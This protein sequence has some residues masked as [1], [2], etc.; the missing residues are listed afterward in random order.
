MPAMLRQVVGDF[1]YPVAIV[2]V[3]VLFAAPL[4][5]FAINWQLM[6]YWI[7]LPAMVL[8]IW[9]QRSRIAFPLFLVLLAHLV[10]SEILPT[11]APG[12]G[13]SGQVV[14]AALVILLPV[15]LVILAFLRERGVMTLWGLYRIS[16]LLNQVVIVAILAT[17]LFGLLPAETARSLW[18][19]S[20]EILHLRLFPAA[21]DQWTHLPQ[22]ALLAA[23]IGGLILLAQY[24]LLGSQLSAALAAVVA[25]VA[26]AGHQVGE[27]AMAAI[28]L[29]A[30]ALILAAALVHDLYRLAFLDELTGLPARRALLSMLSGLSGQYCIAMLDV[31]HFKKFNDRYGHDVGDQVLKMVAACLAR[32][33]GGG[34]AFRYGGEEFTIVFAGKSVE[35]AAPLLETVREEVAHA[36]FVLRGGDRPTRKPK[37]PKSATKPERVGVTISIGAAEP[38]ADLHGP[39]Q[40][41]KAADEALYRA[42]KAGRNILSR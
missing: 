6:P 18:Q 1:W 34:R 10:I 9:F 16:M 20:G 15:N 24:A 5:G 3:V 29:S 39:D 7:A 25:A 35:H 22:P 41:L 32:V 42:K 4:Q 11:G 23:A 12:H 2:V 17:G 38:S 21:F 31:D 14:Y 30:A 27:P 8:A 40:V 19:A 28:Y 13:A 37:E 33:P 36:G 26:L